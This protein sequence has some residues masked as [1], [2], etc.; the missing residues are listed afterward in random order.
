[1]G[2]LASAV[3]LD[4]TQEVPASTSTAT[5]KGT[6]IVDAATGAVLTSYITHTVSQANAAHIHTSPSGPGSIGVVILAFPNLQTNID[7][8]GTNLAYPNVI[9]P[10][11]PPT[12][13]SSTNMTDFRANYLYF[14]VHGDMNN[15]CAPAPNCAA[16]EIR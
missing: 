7:G 4:N 12:A 16:G 2:V 13:L 15:F 11:N 14:N 1:G 6:V 5:G 3:S 9:S 10:P 8:L